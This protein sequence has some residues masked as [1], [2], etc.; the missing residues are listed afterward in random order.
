MKDIRDIDVRFKEFMLSLAEDLAVEAEVP[1]KLTK[2]KIR[3]I[4]SIRKKERI[5]L[6]K[7]RL[8]RNNIIRNKIL[9]VLGDKAFIISEGEGFFVV[10]HIKSVSVHSVKNAGS[11]QPY[12]TI[13]DVRFCVLSLIMW[14]DDCVNTSQYKDAEAKYLGLGCDE[15]FVHSADDFI[16]KGLL[17]EHIDL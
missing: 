2:K 14:D 3:E 8:Y 11:M 13:E 10:Y 16:I 5:E 6:E 15:I 7:E 9:D 12:E 4:E 1:K 17:S